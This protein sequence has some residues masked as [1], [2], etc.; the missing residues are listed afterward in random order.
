MSN[1]YNG[2]MNRETWLVNLHFGDG[3][4]AFIQDQIEEGEE[5]DQTEVADMYQEYVEEA[6]EE[7]IEGLSGFL[8]DLL[9]LDLINWDELAAHVLD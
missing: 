2:W 9:D 5:F 7:E 4:N 8:K 1:T 6:T 3:F